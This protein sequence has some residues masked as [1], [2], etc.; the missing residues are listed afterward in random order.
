MKG[1]RFFSYDWDAVAGVLAAVVAIILDLLNIADEHIIL[2]IVLALMALLFLSFMRHERNNE[3]TAGQVEQIQ[4]MA[5]KIKSSLTIPDVV[6]VGP[7]QLRV[8]SE[9][10]AR[11]MRGDV[12]LYNVCLSM[13]RTQILFDILLRPAIENSQVTFIHFTLDESQKELWKTE[14]LP[15]IVACS[16]GSKVQEPHWCDLSRNLSFI[17]ADT[18]PDGGTEALLSF[19]GEPFMA[20]STERNLPR[21]IFHVLAN[22]ELLPH[23][24]EMERNRRLHK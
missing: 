11:N 15:K 9:Q 8:V 19:W 14:V 6:L 16:G 10:F 17:L 5:E 24:I 12:A 3:H 7:R 18:Q 20:Q 23:F 2:P 1:K 13:Y 4:R 21:Y 22:S